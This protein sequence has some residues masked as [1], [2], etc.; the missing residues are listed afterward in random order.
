MA[1]VE[2]RRGGV[3]VRQPHSPLPLPPYLLRTS[4]L[5]WQLPRR[6]TSPFMLLA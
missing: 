5:D 3:E 2:S 1:R 6:G 4:Y